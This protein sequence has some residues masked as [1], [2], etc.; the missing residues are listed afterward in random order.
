MAFNSAAFNLVANDTND[1]NDIF[2]RDRDTDAD[3]AFDEADAAATER[4][5]LGGCASQANRGS[6]SPFI[7]SDGRYVT[8]SSQSTN[9]VAND[10]NVSPDFFV[11]DRNMRTTQ[12]VSVSSSGTES[13]LGGGGSSISSDGRFAAFSS[14][15][16][17]LVAN[18]TN[19][20]TDVFLRDLGDAPLQGDC[21]APTSTHTVSRL[22]NANGW[23][24]SNVTVTLSAQDN[25]GGSGVQEIRYSA[26]GAQSI[27]ETVF[28]PQNPPIIN[29][30]GTT[31]ITYFATDNAGN[32]ESPAKIL[33]VKIDKGAPTVG[34]VSPAHAATGVSLTAKAEATFSEAMDPNTLSPST[35]TLT[36]QNSST[37]VA[38]TMSYDSTTNKATLNPSSDLASNTTYTATV[39]G[40]DTG[41]KDSA[42]NALV[43]DYSWTFTTGPPPDTTAPKVS[44]ET[45][46]GT[47]V[48]RGTNAIA[49]F[50]E[51]MDPTTITTS[52]FK[53][54]KCSSTTS[55][56]CATQITN[57]TVTQSTDR[58]KAT[59]NP[60]GTSSTLL[61]GRTKF[62]VVVTTGAKDEAGNN[63]DQEA[64]TSG[65]QQKV[66]YFT[67]GRS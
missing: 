5:N 57:V 44:T 46:T 8:F 4:A 67:T 34:S 41:A 54:Y 15:A 21:T 55:T 59:L 17:D 43:Q 24:N 14:Q 19:G 52:T 56:N 32:R 3:G 26:T 64:N 45:P 53:L 30:E 36:R 18:D 10:T 58:L 29:I 9:L 50:S 40:G 42:G 65:N 27:S 62:K 63:L 20:F 23:N 61:A 22:P 60:F 31:T 28:D 16:L 49:T 12:R 7:S 38:A 51:R 66:W 37:P 13:H 33:T 48:A 47:G 35:F 2:V 11:R 1:L 25:E 6:F 39:K